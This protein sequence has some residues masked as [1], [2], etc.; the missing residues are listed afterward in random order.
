MNKFFKI[1]KKNRPLREKKSR[2]HIIFALLAN[3]LLK[4]RPVYSSNYLFLGQNFKL[5]S[6]ML[7]N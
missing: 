4:K 1:K 7:V 2:D 3:S 6:F 5:V